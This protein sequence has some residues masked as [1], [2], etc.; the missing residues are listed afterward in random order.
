MPQPADRCFAQ[1]GLCAEKS[2]PPCVRHAVERVFAVLLAG[3]GIYTYICSA[4]KTNKA[5]PELFRA[6]GFTFLF[7]SHDHEPMHVHVIGNG[8]DAKYVWNGREFAFY[9]Q[10][11]I[12]AGD[13]KRI[14]GLIDENTDIIKRSWIIFFGKEAKNGEN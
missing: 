8:G 10:H 9:E 1:V 5:M 6:F 4:I 13:L 14:K 7:F 12:K 3:I 2:P 11:G